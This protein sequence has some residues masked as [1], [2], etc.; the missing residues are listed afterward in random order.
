M[1][2]RVLHCSSEEACI[3]DNCHTTL[4]QSHRDLY[5]QMSLQEF[6]P[7][8]KYTQRDLDLAEQDIST[9]EQFIAY[10]QRFESQAPAN[11]PG[12]RWSSCLL[13][14]NLCWRPIADI[15]STSCASCIPVD[16]GR[17]DLSASNLIRVSPSLPAH[18][19]SCRRWPRPGR[20]HVVGRS[21]ARSRRRRP[22]TRPTS[23]PEVCGSHSSARWTPSSS[24][25]SCTSAE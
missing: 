15:I 8:M 24:G 18:P 14:S 16:P 6:C 19:R 5:S 17:E 2:S 7:H 13:N 11:P 22:R 9:L 12:G 21:S 4:I 3:S 25:A 10:Q 20:S 23:P 1:I